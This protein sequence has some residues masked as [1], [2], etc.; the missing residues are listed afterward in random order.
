MAPPIAWAKF[1][2][3]MHPSAASRKGFRCAEKLRLPAPAFS[4]LSDPFLL[5]QMGIAVLVLAALDQRE[6]VVLFGD[7]V[8]WRDFAGAAREM[9]R[10][11]MAAPRNCFLP[12]RIG[13]GY[14]LSRESIGALFRKTSPQLAPSA[15][16]VAH[17]SV[18]EVAE[19]KEARRGCDVPITTSR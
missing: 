12:L 2:V 4:S 6:R 1:V 15:L 16:D 9:F 3:G 11:F 7:Y 17:S 19:L 8:W 10:R 18:A 13:G 14:G 5:P